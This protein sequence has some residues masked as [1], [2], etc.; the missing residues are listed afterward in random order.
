MNATSPTN[1]FTA[2][3]LNPSAKLELNSIAAKYFSVMQESLNE[4]CNRNGN[5]FVPLR[6]AIGTGRYLCS[7][8]K[9]EMKLF[10]STLRECLIMKMQKK[11]G[12]YF[13]PA[14]LLT[15]T[16]IIGFSIPAGFIKKKG[17]AFS[18][19][20]VYSKC[21]GFLEQGW[22]EGKD[23]NVIMKI[24]S[25]KLCRVEMQEKG[26]FIYDECWIKAKP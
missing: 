16:G 21:A 18:L 22:H 5:F 9:K 20:E 8:E 15:D 1:V 4:I 2:V 7:P 14:S 13:F 11:D 26:F 19:S 12:I 25:L 10:A 6:A 17:T 3:G 23:G 24:A